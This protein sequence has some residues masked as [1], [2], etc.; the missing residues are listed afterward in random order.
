MVYLAKSVRCHRTTISSGLKRLA[1]HG[2]ITIH[3]IQGMSHEH[4]FAVGIPPIA[5][6]LDL[7]RKKQQHTNASI[8]VTAQQLFGVPSAMTVAPEPANHNDPESILVAHHFPSRLIQSLVAM[9]E[10]NSVDVGE[11]RTMLNKAS[12]KHEENKATH[13]SAVDHCGFLFEKMLKDWVFALKKR[14]AITQPWRPRSGDEMDAN[15]AMDDMRLPPEG[16]RLL[17]S[18]VTS[19]S[20]SLKDGGCIPCPL[21][22]ETVV[23]VHKKTK[24]DWA[25]FQQAIIQSIFSFPSDQPPSCVWYEQWLLVEPIPKPDNTPLIAAGVPESDTRELRSTVDEWISTFIEDEREAVGYGDKVVLLA[26]KQIAGPGIKNAASALEC[27]AAELR[28]VEVV[29]VEEEVNKGS[30]LQFRRY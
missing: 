7:W 11:W 6:R 5:N 13:P 4:A 1:R 27:V 17:R 15:T 28:P 23:A 19:E 9:I 2:L 8:V 3:S 25:L 10:E 22:W 20:L 24:G 29:T 16:R 12:R 30:P 14:L 18:A 21:N 26:S